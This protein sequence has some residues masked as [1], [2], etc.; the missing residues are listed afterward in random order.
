MK[1][2]PWGRTPLAAAYLPIMVM[3]NTVRVMYYPCTQSNFA[4]A[5]PVYVPLPKIE[6]LQ[7]E[8]AVFYARLYK[9]A[10]ERAIQR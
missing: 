2:F 9:K 8:R 7:G 4:S 6:L 1:I 3:D 10:E 5:G